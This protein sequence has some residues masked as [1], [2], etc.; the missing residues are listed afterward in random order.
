[1]IFFELAY[2]QTPSDFVYKPYME[3]NECLK[4]DSRFSTTF[5]HLDSK[6]QKHGIK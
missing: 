5:F 3:K 4:K 6:F 2:N 1:M